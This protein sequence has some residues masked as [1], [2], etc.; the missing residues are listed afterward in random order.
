[1]TYFK[2]LNYEMFIKDT[3]YGAFYFPDFVIDKKIIEYDGIYWHNIEKDNYRNDF[4]KKKGY[5]VLSITEKDFA[6]S[7][8]NITTVNKCVNF[9]RNE[10]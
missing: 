7:N 4:Y 9:I 6:R 10:N 1:M 2:E 3:T 8:K 5:D